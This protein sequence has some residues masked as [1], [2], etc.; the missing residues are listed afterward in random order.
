MGVVYEAVDL[1]LNRKVAVK[2]MT[3]HLFG[4]QNAL[5]RFEREARILARLTHPNIVAIYDFGPIS[6]E[7]AYLAM[8]LLAGT[9]WRSE[10]KRMGRIPPACAA[11]WFDQLLNGLSAAHQAGVVHRDLKPENVNITSHLDMGVRLK[12]LD[13]GV[14]KVH[15]RWSGERSGETRSLTEMGVV[16]GTLAYMSPEQL[17]GEPVDERCDI[18][19]IGVMAVE[20]LTGQLPARSPEGAVLH[21]AIALPEILHACLAYDPKLRCGSVRELHAD[22][23]NALRSYEN[24]LAAP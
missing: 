18:F 8:E 6:G 11:V 16:M 9:S 10:L 12:I 19:S 3:G 13:F 20:A 14:A 24:R 22:L 1:K 4:D 21:S 15:T 23:V 17:R 2:V 7:G 5:R